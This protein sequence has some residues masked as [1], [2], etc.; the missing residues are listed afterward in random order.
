VTDLP[1]ATRVNAT[2]TGA[3]NLTGRVSMVTGA[4]GGIGRVIGAELARLGSTV[5]LVSRGAVSGEQLKRQIAAETGADR[6]EVIAGD[7]STR[8]GVRQVAGEFAARHDRL[9]LLVNNAGA[10]YRKRWPPRRRQARRRLAGA[11]AAAGPVVHVL[12]AHVFGNRSGM[13]GSSDG[14]PR[15]MGM[16]CVGALSWWQI[17]LSRRYGFRSV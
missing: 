17:G 3:V 7:L 4:T 10:H 1:L 13:T 8:K 5:V 16:F 14:P 15:R 6:A 2:T 11:L 9:H 12:P